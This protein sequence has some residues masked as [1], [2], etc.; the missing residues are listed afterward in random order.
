MP[1]LFRAVVTQAKMKELGFR[2]LC[3]RASPVRLGGLCL[4]LCSTGGIITYSVCSME[5]RNVLIEI[6]PN[7]YKMCGDCAVC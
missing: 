5:E 6:T 1:G 3:F 4:K 7:L 2:V